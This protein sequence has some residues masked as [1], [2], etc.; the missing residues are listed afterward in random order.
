MVAEPRIVRMVLFA[1]YIVFLVAGFFVVTH[2]PESFVEVLTVRL[3]L[4]LGCFLTLGAILSSIAVLP[5][6]WW[7]ERCGLLSLITGMI[8]YIVVIVQLKSSPLG[9][10][11][12]VAF[13]L[14]FILRYMETRAFK[15]APRKN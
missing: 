4:M 13:I 12:S 15:L 1:I 3:V 5:G 11:V 10:C 2:P 14:F 7:L 6:L 9:I 8:I